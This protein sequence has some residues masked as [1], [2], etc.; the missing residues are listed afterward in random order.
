[1]AHLEDHLVDLVKNSDVAT[2]SAAAGIAT[3][4][5][6]AVAG[7][8]NVICKVDAA[9]STPTDSG[10]LTVTITTAGGARTITK[11]MHGAGAIDFGVFGLSCAASNTAITAA[12]AAGGGT[13]VVA[14]TYYTTGPNN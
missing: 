2:A 11:Y 4:T 1:M 10:L 3:A 7:R 14:A 6:S 9:Y 8:V 12:L 5:I 13:G